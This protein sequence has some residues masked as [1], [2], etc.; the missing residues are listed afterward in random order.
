ML[1]PETN[2]MWNRYDVQTFA[3]QYRHNTFDFSHQNTSNS[4][5]TYNSAY[6]PG[7][8]C[9][10]LTNNLVGRFHSSDTNQTFGQWTI[11]GN[12]QLFAVTKYVIKPV[13]PLDLRQPLTNNGPFSNNKEIPTLIPENNSSQI[14]TRLSLNF[15]IRVTPL[16]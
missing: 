15:A 5:H 3:R 2:V 13:I 12:F 4:I 10:I 16:F 6:Q 7:G 8:T 1:F 11:I 9:S 14:L